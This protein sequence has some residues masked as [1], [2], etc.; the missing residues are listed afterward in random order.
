MGNSLVL[1]QITNIVSIALEKC[2]ENVILFKL[3]WYKVFVH[4][5]LKL[6]KFMMDSVLILLDIKYG[7]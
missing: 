6:L 2:K 3:F 5:K 4:W 7:Q 1:L